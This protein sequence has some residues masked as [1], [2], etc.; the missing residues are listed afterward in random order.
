[1]SVAPEYDILSYPPHKGIKN[2]Y[3]CSDFL[4]HEFPSG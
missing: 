2:K 1:M 4:K 3:P